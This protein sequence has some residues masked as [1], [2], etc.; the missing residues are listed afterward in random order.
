VVTTANGK[1][2]L[3]VYIA[4]LKKKKARPFDAV[5]LDHWMPKMDG[6]QVAKHILGANPRQRIVFASA[7]INETL[8]DAV[9]QLKQIVELLQKPFGLDTLVNVLEDKGI[10]EELEKLN[11]R[12]KEIKN[13]NPTHDQVRGLLEGLN[14]LQKAK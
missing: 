1:E 5:V 3:D 8:G 2:C 14:K 13:L 10:Y 6:M 12:I 11:V 4:E 9:K 7:Y